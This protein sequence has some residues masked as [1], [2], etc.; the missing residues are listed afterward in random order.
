[1]NTSLHNLQ[2]NMAQSTLSLAQ[3]EQLVEILARML[4]ANF[5]PHFGSILIVR[6]WADGTY[7]TILSGNL[8]NG[9]ACNC[10]TQKWQDHPHTGLKLVTDACL[11]SDAYVGHEVSEALQC[12][13][14]GSYYYGR[15]D[16]AVGSL[17]AENG[18]YVLSLPLDNGRIVASFRASYCWHQSRISTS[19]SEPWQHK[20]MLVSLAEVFHLL[21][22]QDLRLAD[23]FEEI[24]TALR[25]RETTNYGTNS[26][27]IRRR[28][29]HRH[30]VTIYQITNR[31]NSK[32]PLVRQAYA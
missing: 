19:I 29:S 25:Q 4:Y 15:I 21:L 24:T 6:A 3:Q 17:Y 30:T 20:L 12:A 5:D 10:R 23:S 27:M 16:P 14:P 1:M 18:H 13:N 26:A 11:N 32:L 9:T 8:D 22:S 28:L 7:E 31:A 2:L